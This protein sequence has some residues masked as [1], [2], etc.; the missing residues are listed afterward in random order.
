[1]L[2]SIPEL[3]NEIMNNGPI[4]VGMSLYEDFY[5]YSSGV[6]EHVA[7]DFS[8]GHAVKMIGWGHADDGRL[9]WIC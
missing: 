8:G 7:G 5:S 6:Y 2:T 4:M 1:V 9:Y 3:Q